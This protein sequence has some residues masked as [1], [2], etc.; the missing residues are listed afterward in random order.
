MSAIPKTMRQWQIMGFDSIDCLE[1]H[2]NIETPSAVLPGQI[3][4]KVYAVTIE[5][6]D[7]Q[8]VHSS[9]PG[10]NAKK[11]ATGVV[12]G[13]ACACEIVQIAPGAIRKWQLG[14]KVMPIGVKGFWGGMVNRDILATPGRGSGRDGTLRE[15]MVVDEVSS[16]PPGPPATRSDSLL[17]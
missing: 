11:F 5:S 8:V 3:L 15:Y 13:K 2:D 6:S 12:P 14:D 10:I 9:H 7:L 4:V 1:L 16:P 17:E